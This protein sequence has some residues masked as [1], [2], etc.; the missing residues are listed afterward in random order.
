MNEQTYVQPENS[1]NCSQTYTISEIAEI[2][3]VSVRTAYNLCSKTTDFKVIRVGKCVRVHRLSFDRWFS[4][5]DVAD[6]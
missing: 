5:C 2:L 3:K 4:G 1:S 6:K